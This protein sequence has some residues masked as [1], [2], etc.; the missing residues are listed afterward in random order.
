MQKKL[1]LLLLTCLF[2]ITVSAQTET[3]TKEIVYNGA[4]AAGDNWYLDMQLGGDV[5][6][7]P[8]IKTVDA[9]NGLRLNTSLSLGKWIMP[10]FGLRLQLKSM[11]WKGATATTD[12]RVLDPTQVSMLADGSVE[13]NIFYLNPHLDFTLSLMSC[14]KGG[15]AASQKWDVIPFLGLGYMYAFEADGV[16]SGNCLTGHFGLMGKYRICDHWDVNLELST[17]LLPDFYNRAA[18][19]VKQADLAFTIGATYNIGG[20][21]F[22]QRA[23]K[24]NNNYYA[25]AGNVNNHSAHAHVLYTKPDTVYVYNNTE[26]IIY[27][28]APVSNGTAM[29]T[30]AKQKTFDQPFQIALIEFSISSDEPKMDFETQYYNV[31]AFVAAYPESTLRLD[32]YCDAATGTTEYNDDLARRRAEKVRDILVNNYGVDAG[33][34]VLNP[35]GSREQVYEKTSLNRIVRITVLPK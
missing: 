12:A 18:G 31:A 19:P 17:A 8:E 3:E 11:W 14:F 29:A 35:L 15:W 34:I 28:A 1:L 6:F 23:H 7:N 21:K 33:R 4:G 20:H 2:G 13:Y 16:K 25:S 30:A 5:L 27:R 32:A 24:D 9:S 22:G 10:Y 26:T